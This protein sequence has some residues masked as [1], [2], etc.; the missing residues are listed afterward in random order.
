[1]ISGQAH[2]LRQLLYNLVNNALKFARTDLT[3]VVTVKSKILSEEELSEGLDPHRNYLELQVRDN[4]V[5]FDPRHADKIFT[6]F[7]RL[8]D[9]RQFPGTGIGLALCKKVVQRHGGLIRAE[10]SPGAGAAF[11]VVLPL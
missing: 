1:M 4:G 11:F 9:R 2:Q 3:P 10:A 5:G 8:H 6:L 7:Q